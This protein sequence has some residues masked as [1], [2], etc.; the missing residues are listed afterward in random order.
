MPREELFEELEKSKESEEK[1]ELW[2]NVK[3]RKIKVNPYRL[4]LISFEKSS[5]SLFLSIKRL[6]NEFLQK[7][8]DMCL[9]DIKQTHDLRNKT[10]AIALVLKCL[11]MPVK[12]PRCRPTFVR[13]SSLQPTSDWEDE[14]R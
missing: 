2:M 5:P 1:L 14:L 8:V 7:Q 11:G 3:K 13:R 10:E 4:A 12:D 9:E 6:W